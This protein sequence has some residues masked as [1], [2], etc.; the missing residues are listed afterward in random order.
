MTQGGD[1]WGLHTHQRIGTCDQLPPAFDAGEVRDVCTRPS[2][3]QKPPKVGTDDCGIRVRDGPPDVLQRSP[4]MHS[5]RSSGGMTADACLEPRPSS[6][7]GSPPSCQT[8]AG[9]STRSK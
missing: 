2:S 6:T 1:V 4:T 5:T 9:P 7:P 8:L 3:Q